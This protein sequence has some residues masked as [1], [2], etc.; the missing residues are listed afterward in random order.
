V[1]A[2]GSYSIGPSAPLADGRY[3]AQVEQDDRASPPDRGFSA[4][5][6]FAIHNA[7]PTVDLDSLGASPLLTSTP[8]LRG[9]GSASA[10]DAPTIYLLI[11]PGPDTSRT[12]VL[13]LNTTRAA[14]G[15]FSFTVTAG[16]PDGQYTAVATQTGGS[17]AVGTS[18]PVTFRIKV[19]P[20][21]LTL[22]QPAAGANVSNS[23]PRFAGQAGDMLG[24]SPTVA[25][26][27]YEGAGTSGRRV[28]TI[29]VRTSGASWSARW[30][31]KLR[32]G[33]YTVRATQHDDAG[34]TTTTP[35]HTFLIVPP[36][37]VI[38][39][40]LHLN[41]ANVAS[42]PLTCTAP[43]GQVCT[44]SVLVLTVRSYQPVPGGPVGPVRVLFA[45]VSIASGKTQIVRR[46]VSGA[47]ARTLRRAAPVKVRVTVRF[48]TDRGATV[49]AAA[50]RMLRLAS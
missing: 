42:V 43:A 41:P 33:L 12:P 39:S 8:T 28:G 7:P 44:G 27:L 20:P 11:Y 19:H 5:V 30:P 13:I 14:D 1:E 2:D 6:T 32:L 18:P 46:Q 16:L 21:A 35:A 37:T 29:H 22:L 9:T 31:H 15:G 26:T 40:P 23:R 49:N 17:G 45:Y 10:A 34:H 24:D 3:T 48:S 47:V 4:P 25:V 36:P 38:G 50:T